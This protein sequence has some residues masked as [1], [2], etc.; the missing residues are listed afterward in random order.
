[1]CLHT[2]YKDISL[3]IR[4]QFWMQGHFWCP[5]IQIGQNPS[6]LPKTSLW[7]YE[8]GFFMSSYSQYCFNSIVQRCVAWRAAFCKHKPRMVATTFAA[9]SN[10][11]VQVC[12]F[13]VM[14]PN[15]FFTVWS[16]FTRDPA[17]NNLVV[18][19][20]QHMPW[21]WGIVSQFSFVPDLSISFIN[22]LQ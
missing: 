19:G 12:Q 13:L 15:L 2:L 1:M 18:F 4:G 9:V 17:I 21:I 11:Q 22:A 14:M 3:C 5:Q 7:L 8:P 10:L 20:K 6:E 16:N